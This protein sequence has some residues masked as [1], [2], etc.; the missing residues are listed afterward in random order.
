[1]LTA[2]ASKATGSVNS[3]LMSVKGDTVLL[4]NKSLCKCLLNNWHY[5]SLYHTPSSNKY[6]SYAHL[7]VSVLNK[8]QS[9]S[10]PDI[11]LLDYIS[12]IRQHCKCSDNCFIMALI[13][14]NRIICNHAMYISTTTTTVA[15]NTP[16]YC[17]T[18]NNE[19]PSPNC[20]TQAYS[21][22]NAPNITIFTAYTAHRF[23]LVC[24]IL[25]I[26]FVD[27]EFYKNTYYAQVGGVGLA[28]LNIL[29][30]ECLKLLQY[31]LYVSNDE[32]MSYYNNMSM[33]GSSSVYTSTSTAN[34]STANTSTSVTPTLVTATSTDRSIPALIKSANMMMK[35]N[36][37]NSIVYTFPECVNTANTVNTNV[38]TVD[39]CNSNSD[40]PTQADIM[41]W[42]S[43]TNSNSSI[44]TSTS[45]NTIYDMFSPTPDHVT[46]V[47]TP[48]KYN[49][50][51]NYY[52]G[53]CASVPV[54]AFPVTSGYSNSNGDNSRYMQMSNGVNSNQGYARYPMYTNTY[55]TNNTNGNVHTYVTYDTSN[56]SYRS[57]Y[58]TT[59]TT[60]PSG[61]QG[62][63]PP[64]MY[65][66]Y[67]NAV[68]TYTIPTLYSTITTNNT[69]NYVQ[70]HPSNNNGYIYG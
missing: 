21:H 16:N 35:S 47:N 30:L 40:I 17:Y 54:P 36:S 59:H 12:M 24:I 25:A 19:Q 6:T 43:N 7:D 49:Q 14:M 3:P 56:P 32:F 65:P 60:A 15:V 22:H 37:S 26:K 29:E 27:D 41:E 5:V 67:T 52:E 42:N 48:P 39:T 9:A 23:I 70:T 50:K 63:I 33:D 8:F 53:N 2:T 38:L 10:I 18:N 46:A 58:P 34:V 68:P 51:F 61:P 66:S 4:L 55:S 62:Y 28:E 31:Q 1:M 57:Y 20:V 13:Y 64:H 44:S 69:N 45:C 11:S